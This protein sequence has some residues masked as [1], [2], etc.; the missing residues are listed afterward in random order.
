MRLLMFVNL[1]SPRRAACILAFDANSNLNILT[2]NT[3]FYVRRRGIAYFWQLVCND[4][5]MTTLRNV[6]MRG[7]LKLYNISYQSQNDCRTKAII[8]PSEG[9]DQSTHKMHLFAGDND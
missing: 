4:W 2:G 1:N 5:P 8:K 7:F 3:V 9:E 6:Y